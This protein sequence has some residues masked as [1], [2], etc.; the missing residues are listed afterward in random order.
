M[1]NYLPEL[2]PLLESGRIDP[3]PVLT[4]DLPLE[5]GPDGYQVMNSRQEGSVKVALT[6]GA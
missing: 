2:W 3:S 5:Q 6:P 4:H 1:K